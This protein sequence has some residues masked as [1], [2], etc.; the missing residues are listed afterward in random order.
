MSTVDH[1]DIRGSSARPAIM[2]VIRRELPGTRNA[3]PAAG[4][5][6]IGGHEDSPL[7]CA[8]PAADR[9]CL[10]RAH[11]TS[12]RASGGAA[13]L[14]LEWCALE[15]AAYRPDKAQQLTAERRDDL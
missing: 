3:G 7:P 5:C 9:L 13:Y 4:A 15:F 6:R 8:T 12:L 2:V 1:S 11:G 14:L 10:Y